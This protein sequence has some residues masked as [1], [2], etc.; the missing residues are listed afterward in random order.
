MGRRLTRRAPYEPPGAAAVLRPVGSGL[1]GIED[2]TANILAQ[3]RDAEAL[4]AFTETA[5]WQAPLHNS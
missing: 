5:Q 4:L 1:P 3:A 2:F